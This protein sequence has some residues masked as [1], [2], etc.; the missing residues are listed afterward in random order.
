M[1]L[2]F[3]I[4]STRAEDWTSIRKLLDDCAALAREQRHRASPATW[5]RSRPGLPAQEMGTNLF[6]IHRVP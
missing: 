3:G 5:W 2:L 6:E 4:R 1:N